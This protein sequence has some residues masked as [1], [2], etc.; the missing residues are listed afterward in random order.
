MSART[1]II[2]AIVE[3]LKGIDGS[4]KINVFNN[5]FA[6]HKF[7]DEVRDFP[8]L[9]VV[10]GH[11]TREYHPSAF[12]WGFLNV[13]IKAYVKGETPSQDLEY[14]L[15]DIETIIDANRD[16]VYDASNANASTTEI[17]ITSIVT[18][19]GLLVPYGVGEVNLQVR[20]QV[21]N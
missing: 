12:K 16:L 19:E 3:K 17:L 14:L 18:D 1:S 20:Y 15:E 11:E 13:S 8:A 7:W 9:Y 10:A 6:I 2:N 5:V 4:G 21:L